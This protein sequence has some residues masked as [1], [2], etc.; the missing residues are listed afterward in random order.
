MGK[1]LLQIEERITALAAELADLQTAARVLRSLN[2]KTL[3][4]ATKREILPPDFRRDLENS[5]IIEAAQ[6]VLDD[7]SEPMHFKEIAK[8]AGDRGY[9]SGPGR[10]INPASFWQLLKRNKDKF[11]AKGS[12]TFSLKQSQ[13]KGD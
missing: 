9:S 11:E 10:K 1:E 6:K 7:Y 3:K 13:Q 8:A 2:G 4:T 12:G 5:T